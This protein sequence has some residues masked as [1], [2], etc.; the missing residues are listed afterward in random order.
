MS[1]YV[2]VKVQDAHILCNLHPVHAQTDFSTNDQEGKTKRFKCF[3]LTC[4]HEP[5]PQIPQVQI[6]PQEKEPEQ[7]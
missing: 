6:P 5:S 1:I 2:S 7:Q 3:K 4:L